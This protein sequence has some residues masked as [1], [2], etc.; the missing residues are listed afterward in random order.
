MAETPQVLPETPNAFAADPLSELLGS[1]RLA[2]VVLF[3][4]EFREPWWLIAPASCQLA[5]LLPFR[6]EHII[7]FHIVAEGGCW[8]EVKDRERIWLEAGDVVLMP[9]GDGHDLFGRDKPDQGVSPGQLLPR[10]ISLTVWQSQVQRQ[11]VPS[12]VQYGTSGQW[13]NKKHYGMRKIPIALPILMRQYC[14][15]HLKLPDAQLLKN[16]G[17][18]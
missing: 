8:L 12:S 9:Y 10:K 1:M 15:Y 17:L 11:C 5:K 13:N 7:P 18:P 4:A 14:R 16:L 2:G 6:T 3:R